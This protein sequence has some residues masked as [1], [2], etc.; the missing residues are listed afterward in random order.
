MSEHCDLKTWPWGPLS[1]SAPPQL[2]SHIKFRADSPLCKA[3][4]QLGT[5]GE[6]VIGE[7]NR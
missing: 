3:A 7:L 4:W 6:A 5:R 1:Y 2:K